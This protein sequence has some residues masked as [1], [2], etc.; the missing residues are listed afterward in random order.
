[1]KTEDVKSW[2]KRYNLKE[3]FQWIQLI[4]LHPQN[5][6]YQIRF[7]ILIC[8]LLSVKQDEFENQSLNR[9]DIIDFFNENESLL[10]RMC[11]MQEDFEPF[12][13]F[14]LTPVFITRKKYHFFYGCLEMPHREAKHL[15][16]IY[17]G[18]KSPTEELIQ[19]QQLIESYFV[20]QNSLLNSFNIQ[21]EYTNCENIEGVYIPSQSF[22]DVL[23]QDLII[24]F[25]IPDSE[26]NAG[27]LSA[28]AVDD[29]ID[30]CL[31][32]ES[33]KIL[34]SLILN[35]EGETYFLLPQTSIEYLSSKAIEIAQKNKSN[36]QIINLGFKRRIENLCLR[37]FS[38][39]NRVW[40][41][42]TNE[43]PDHDL[44]KELDICFATYVENR[45]LL[46]LCHEHFVKDL[47]FNKAHLKADKII[48]A[49]KKHKILG[50]DIPFFDGVIGLNVENLQIQVISV[51]ELLRIGAFF[52]PLER[53]EVTHQNSSTFNICD[54]EYIFETFSNKFRK[55]SHVSF[56]KYLINEKAFKGQL[57]WVT[58]TDY[59]DL[60]VNYIAGGNFFMRS[61]QMPDSLHFAPHDASNQYN[62][63]KY[64]LYLNPVYEIVERK[65]G[66]KFNDI[67]KRKDEIYRIADSGWMDFV[68]LIKWESRLI[69]F[70]IPENFFELAK[71]EELSVVMNFLIPF[72]TD[73]VS[74]I[75]EEFL[76]LLNEIGVEEDSEYSIFITTQSFIN[77]NESES[78]LKGHFDF[79][80]S[81]APLVIKTTR[82]NRL[83][84]FRT[85]IV[86]NSN[87]PRSAL[88]RIFEKEDNSG[89]RELISLFLESFKELNY[90]NWKSDR[91]KKII[92]KYFP[93]GKKKRFS[94]DFIATENPRLNDYYNYVSLD[95][96]DINKANK[97]FAEYIAKEKIAKRDYEG[98]E[99][100]DI[101][102]KIF[103]F[104]QELLENEIKQFTPDLLIYA[105]RQIE[106]IEGKNEFSKVKV[107]LD[108]SR[109][110]TYDIK[111]TELK[112]KWNDRTYLASIVKQII[113][114]IL[115]VNPKGN[116][117]ADKIAWQWLLGIAA[118]I[119]DTA[120]IYEALR[121]DLSPH[122]LRITDLYKI[123]DIKKEGKFDKN[124]Y[125]EDLARNR[126]KESKSALNNSLKLQGQ[127]KI[128]S[129]ND[130]ISSDTPTEIELLHKNFD[131][132]FQNYFNVSFQ[133]CISVLKAL[134]KANL[135]SDDAFPVSIVDAK[136]ILSLLHSL[137]I[138]DIDGKQLDRILKFLSISYEEFRDKSSMVPS[139]LLRFRKRFNIC[140]LIKWE[141]NQYIWGN[142]MC[143]YSFR[144]WVNR[145]F[146]GGLPFEIE[147]E[148]INDKLDK[149]HQFRSAE[150]E[151]EAE[152]SAKKVL[153]D[154][155][156]IGRL[157]K[158]NLISKDLP[159]K[160]DCGEIDLLCVDRN[161]KIIYVLEAKYIHQRNRLYDMHIT[162]RDF[163]DE[164]SKKR[165]YQ[166]LLK[167]KEFVSQNVKAF[168]MYFQCDEGEYYKWSIKE[169]FIVNDI[170]FAAYH[171][172]YSVDF[173]LLD[174]LSSYLMKESRQ[175]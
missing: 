97:Y 170:V 110:L 81:N 71:S 1:M 33:H 149:I 91:V 134:T 48:A 39:R 88:V 139:E 8:I 27:H 162:F 73:H 142:Q 100:K 108:L 173:I 66:G 20:A 161:N 98:V 52:L 5:Q 114:S 40:G 14:K 106:L 41:L 147:N 89:E 65:F 93:L 7:E 42:Y 64:Q 28:L 31:N 154:K 156:V 166:K 111:E 90:L 153:G 9:E 74:K 57:E 87:S 61:G 23:K 50:A 165:Y 84:Y 79:A 157:K 121:Y 102:G 55:E 117:R 167:K 126:A 107:G 169:A 86:L 105:Y 82:T 45:L 143:S 4:S 46:F 138:F 129:S 171:R 10:S 132:A 136:R 63:E 78:A 70:Y 43:N 2:F 141:D 37:F 148:D 13:Q 95:E 32:W 158:F 104:L 155:N 58:L 17:W 146:E 67:Y 119:Q 18:I 109:D 47:Q 112:T 135:F 19:V 35:I 72:F 160:P 127:S 128:A 144:I 3:L 120:S 131:I 77:E 163:F 130:T 137:Q 11:F 85:F 6:L 150:L 145:V 151:K 92:D 44:L 125:Y 24:K 36:E 83:N 26:I 113:H 103:N 59:L 99:A 68:Y 16:D 123:E 29:I 101:S 53:E 38:Y 75:K 56:I 76:H 96:S 34:G 159:A 116:V 60:F 12:P 62:E 69:W 22:Y 140:P 175:I 49:I 115:K 30:H 152:K 133:D 80:N 124:R 54:L 25:K 172:D 122:I 168:L 15:I 174:D 164:S 94:V 118:T 21:N 51:F